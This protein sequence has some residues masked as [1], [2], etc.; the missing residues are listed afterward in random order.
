M[1]GRTTKERDKHN[2]KLDH[3]KATHT[4][5]PNDGENISWHKKFQRLYM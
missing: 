4:S 5:P 2:P 1:V 3:Q